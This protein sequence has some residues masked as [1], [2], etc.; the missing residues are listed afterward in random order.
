[1][2]ETRKDPQ[3]IAENDKDPVVGHAERRSARDEEAFTAKVDKIV[4]AEMPR[5]FAMCEEI[6]DDAAVV[7][8]GLSFKDR[9][10]MI[11]AD[12]GRQRHFIFSSAEYAP[13]ELTARS[14][15]CTL[16]LVWADQAQA[17]AKSA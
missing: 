11:I 8:W 6:D 15:H 2:S 7:A 4:A 9:A 14:K 16:R 17:Q 3:R 13:R 12:D 5:M 1:M 10:E